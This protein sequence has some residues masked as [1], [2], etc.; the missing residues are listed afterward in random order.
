MARLGELLVAA[1][2]LDQDQIERALQAQVVWGGRLGTN[3]IELG[4]LDLDGISR[5]L[6]R[7]HGLPAAL[8]RHFDKADRELQDRL[9]EEL[10]QRWSVVPL[11]H[12]GAEKKKIAVAVLDPLPADALAALADALLCDPSAIVVS[13][14]AEMR[15]RYHLER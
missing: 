9:P 15:V 11:L 2:L 1:R 4:L 13:V 3:L 8:A 12:I 14:A 6:G 5:A 10:A 7:Q